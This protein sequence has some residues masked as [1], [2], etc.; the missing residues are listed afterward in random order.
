MVHLKLMNRLMRDHCSEIKR[1]S[2]EHYTENA[3]RNLQSNDINRIL[4]CFAQSRGRG[5]TESPCDS[6]DVYECE[7]D[8]YVWAICG[9]IP[10]Y[11]VSVTYSIEHINPTTISNRVQIYVRL[12]NIQHRFVLL[13]CSRCCKTKHSESAWSIACEVSH[14][15]VRFLLLFLFV[16]R[17]LKT[18]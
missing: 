6:F 15:C 3:H 14:L 17:T 8:S 12:S 2:L 1:H 9:H 18:A 10:L 11:T 7:C 13:A 4:C 16:L 5:Q